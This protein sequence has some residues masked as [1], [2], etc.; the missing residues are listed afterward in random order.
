[1]LLTAS[2]TLSAQ[3]WLNQELYPF[4]S[5][6]LELK[7]GKM[8]YVDQGSGPVLLF[9]HGTP[10]WSFLYRD[11]IKEFSQN[12][13]C[14]AIDHIGF[15]LSDKPL[16]FAGTPEAHSKNLA[17]FI[18]ALDLEEI[19]LVVHDF[20]G[21]IGLGT[22]MTMPERIKQIVLFNSW[23]WE[24]KSSKEVQKADKLLNSWLGRFLYLRLNFSPK[25]LLKKAYADPKK[26]TK[27]VHKHYLAPFPDKDSR[28]SL[29]KIGQS[30]AGSSD[31]YEQQ[32]AKLSSL[33]QKNWLIIWGTEDKF[34]STEYLAKWRKRLPTAQVMEL[35]SGH[36]VQEEQTRAAIAEL[37]NFLHSS[38]QP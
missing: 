9:V 4:E 11:F 34:I 24:T 7:S 23:L 6:H 38:E 27:A 36:F 37:R 13:R 26:L 30:L 35:E 16:D 21:P 32:W 33:E 12:Y 25:T 20:G 15:G 31:W 8:H 5:K 10:T 18:T 28:R 22:A 2:T 19:T 14:I 3:S 29:L 1:M 17:E